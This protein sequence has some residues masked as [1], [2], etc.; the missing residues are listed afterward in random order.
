MARQVVSIGITECESNVSPENSFLR[1][2]QRLELN[3]FLTS[4][5]T[6]ANAKTYCDKLRNDLAK[7]KVMRFEKTNVFIRSNY[8]LGVIVNSPNKLQSGTWHIK[9]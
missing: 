6:P 9:F 8:E 4:K 3:I 5:A 2:I 1:L 7:L